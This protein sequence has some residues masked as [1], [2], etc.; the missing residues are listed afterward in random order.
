MHFSEVSV[1]LREGETLKVSV[2]R[3]PHLGS[4]QSTLTVSMHK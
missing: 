3:G 1:S 4:G 2:Y